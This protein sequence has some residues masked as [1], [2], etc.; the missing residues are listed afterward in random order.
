M[1]T[2]LHL[3]TVS[4]LEISLFGRHCNKGTAREEACGTEICMGGAA[5]G[6]EVGRGGG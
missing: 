6:M 1:L 2:C 5:W 4:I 3:W